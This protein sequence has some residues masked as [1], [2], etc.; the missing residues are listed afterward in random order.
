[1]LVAGYRIENHMRG[2]GG[3]IITHTK[4]EKSNIIVE[5]SHIAVAE[6][7]FRSALRGAETAVR[8][9]SSRFSTRGSEELEHVRHTNSCS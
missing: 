3:E 6:A 7:E 1:V 9:L 8:P 4:Y 5:L 2:V